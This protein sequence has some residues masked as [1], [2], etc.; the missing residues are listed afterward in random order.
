MEGYY[1][2]NI[3]LRNSI[4]RKH[5][6]VLIGFVPHQAAALLYWMSGVATLVQIILVC[7]WISSAIAFHWILSCSRTKFFAKE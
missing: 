2:D 5:M 4:R 3:F 1:Y 7:M 6:M